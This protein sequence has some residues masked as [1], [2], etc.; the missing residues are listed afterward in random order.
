VIPIA[1]LRSAI[2]VPSYPWRQNNS[3]AWSNAFV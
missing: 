1:F 3:S 2:D